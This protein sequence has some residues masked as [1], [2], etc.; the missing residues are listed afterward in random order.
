MRR[1]SIIAVLLLLSSLCACS[2]KD[3]AS[4]TDG[5]RSQQTATPSEQVL[6]PG[7]DWGLPSPFTF[8]PRGPGYIHLSLIYDTL[9]WKDHKGIVPWLAEQWESGPNGLQWTF[10]LRRDVLWQDGRPLTAGDVRFTFEILRKHPVEWFPVSAI[11][12]V[13]A[14]DAHTVVFR[15]HKP[16]APF[17][18]RVAGNVPIIPEHIWKHVADPRATADL[19]RLVGSGPYRLIRY[20]KA[21]GAYAYTANPHFFLGTP[22]IRKILFVPMGDPVSALE[23]GL[24]DQANIPASLL[25]RFAKRRDF[26]ILSGPSYWVLTLRFNCKKDPF[27]HKAVRQAFACA[28]DR[29]MLIR[30]AVPGGLQGA[31]PGS[32]GFLPP[33]SNWFAPQLQEHY[34]YNPARAGELLE[35]AGVIDRDVDGTREG[36]D[37]SAMQFTLITTPQHLREA[38]ALQLMLRKIGFALQPKAVDIKSLDALVREGRFDLAL[39]GHGGLGA[40]PSVITGFGATG[41]G[42][43]AFSIPAGPAYRTLAEQLRK[44]SDHSQRLQLCYRM[45]Q[46]YAEE[47]PALPLYYPI[48]FGAYRPRVLDAWFYTAHGGVGIGIPLPYHQL[49][50]IKGSPL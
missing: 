46:L 5:S 37:A 9:I 35:A 47:L 16:Y 31:K 29:N 40:D 49:V 4:T 36:S 21:Q 12:A 41:E 43:R 38:E 26:A 27:S 23:R 10:H 45:Q 7:G 32:S 42:L 1:R 28:I 30:Q 3:E 8:Y 11:A 15:L 20:D 24:V 48:W 13:D 22:H 34:P 18:S 50:L 17:L 2:G 33:D 6:L 39:T 44:S 19:N 25:P 14:V